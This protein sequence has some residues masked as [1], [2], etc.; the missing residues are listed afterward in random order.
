MLL[1]L[2]GLYAG[3]SASENMPIYKRQLRDRARLL[4]TKVAGEQKDL[5][6]VRDEDLLNYFQIT[7]L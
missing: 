6:S 2:S 4:A 1:F 7:G 3:N 5:L